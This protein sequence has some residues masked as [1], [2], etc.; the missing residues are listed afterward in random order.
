M[1]HR[2]KIPR[3]GYRVPHFVL[4]GTVA[5][6]VLTTAGS[7]LFA[8]HL[9][10][11]TAVL[12]AT[13]VALG[14]G[15]LVFTAGLRWFVVRG[16]RLATDRML[17]AVAWTGSER[18]LDVGCGPGLALVGAAK[19]LQTGKVV[20]VDQ[21]MVIHGERNNSR[22][23]TLENARIE[24]VADRVEV[25]EGDASAMRFGD[26]DFDV[27]MSS[28][29]FHHLPRD[30]RFRALREM[31]RVTRPGGYVLITDERTTELAA[32]LRDLG[33]VDVADRK[34]MVAAR[35]LTARKTDVSA[36]V[37]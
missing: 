30:V 35:V 33:M 3:Y 12:G 31:A 28:F 17:D 9:S 29:V 6:L 25:E 2:S 18:V 16:R 21:W 37:G 27:V 8:G 23:I 7:V 19:R 36:A 15:I 26:D 14:L 34:L 11:W 1:T 32:A 4:A 24:G 22:E 13:S 20:G 5:G 10:P